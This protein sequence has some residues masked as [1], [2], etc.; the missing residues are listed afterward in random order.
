[1]ILENVLDQQE[2]QYNFAHVNNMQVTLWW[3]H[4]L[5]EID[6]VNM[7]IQAKVRQHKRWIF[8]KHHMSRDDYKRDGL[9]FNER[10]AA[11][12]ALEVRHIIR[13]IESE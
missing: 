9:H 2:N 4:L 7:F 10:G 1:M 5:D 11:K 3:R 6:Q 13:N 8:L 12:Y